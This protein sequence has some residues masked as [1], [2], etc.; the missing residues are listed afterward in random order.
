MGQNLQQKFTSAQNE[1]RIAI[2]NF[3]INQQRPFNLHT[4]GF[5][6]LPELQQSGEVEFSQIT[7]VL[8]SEDG[9][10]VDKSGNVEFI[11]PVSAL[12]TSHRVTLADGRSFTAMCAIDAIGST[13]TF[14][15]DVE[16]N[17]V[18]GECGKPVWVSLRNGKLH[19]YSPQDLHVLTFRL[20]DIANWAGS[21]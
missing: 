17:S 9:M 21:C 10:V 3:I 18:C 19:Q 2:M 14:G 12:P 5:F 4:D 1:V 11:Y 8:H 20:E 6:A 15:Q 16:I 13:F 7:D